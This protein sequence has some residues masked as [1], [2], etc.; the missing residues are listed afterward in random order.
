MG[1]AVAFQQTFKS[2]IEKLPR[3]GHAFRVD[4]MPHAGGQ[5]PLHPG[6]GQS[7]LGSRQEHGLWWNHGIAVA[8]GEQNW[9]YLASRRRACQQAGKSHKRGRLTA[10]SQMQRQHGAL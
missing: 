9:R 2:E 1:G 10:Q 5:M 3:H 7:Q 4:A 8:M 6:P